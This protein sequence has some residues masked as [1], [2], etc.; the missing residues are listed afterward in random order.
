M[1]KR[2]QAIAVPPSLDGLRLNPPDKYES[3]SPALRTSASCGRE[4]S[5]RRHHYTTAPEHSRANLDG[6]YRRGRPRPQRTVPADVDKCVTRFKEVQHTPTE[7]SSAPSRNGANSG[8]HLRSSA[9]APSSLKP[10]LRRAPSIPHERKVRFAERIERIDAVSEPGSEAVQP[11][12]PVIST[13]RPRTQSEKRHGPLCQKR[14]PV[15]R[16][17][18]GD[19]SMPDEVDPRQS[20]RI[21]IRTSATPSSGSSYYVSYGSTRLQYISHS[22]SP[23]QVE[24]QGNWKVGQRLRR[25]SS[26]Q[27]LKS[28]TSGRREKQPKDD[29]LAVYRSGESPT[30]ANVGRRRKPLY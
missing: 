30:V 8:I 18:Y 2:N 10:I 20:T 15:D 6:D 7:I 9:S 22:S 1:W 11:Q 3:H 21:K 26:Y 23:A 16:D 19:H 12:S 27:N 5:S 25:L 29:G 24:V 4:V 13:Q 28:L 17:G 14:R